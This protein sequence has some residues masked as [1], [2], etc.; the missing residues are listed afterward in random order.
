MRH[1]GKWT[2]YTPW[3][4]QGRG[5][6]WKTVFLYRGAGQLSCLLEVGNIQETRR[7]DLTLLGQVIWRWRRWGTIGLTGGL[8]F[9]SKHSHKRMRREGTAKETSFHPQKLGVSSR[10]SL[11]PSN[12]ISLMFLRCFSCT[13]H[14]PECHR[15]YNSLS[16]YALS[17]QSA[18]AG[19]TSH[20]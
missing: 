17:K 11:S 7:F 18:H 1:S 12:W 15:L 5:A 4:N 14:G 13:C 3:N 2:I 8:P 10:F 16:A 19:M 9:E 20:P 6:L